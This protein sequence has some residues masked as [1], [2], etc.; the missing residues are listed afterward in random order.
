MD[1][2]RERLVVIA[3]VSVYT[4]VCLEESSFSSSSSSSS[5]SSEYTF[6]KINEESDYSSIQNNKHK[7]NLLY[8]NESC[9]FS[10]ITN[11][12]YKDFMNLFDSKFNAL[13]CCIEEE[14]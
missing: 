14:L 2:Q 5:S 6:E 10:L 1:Y 12:S 8:E 11:N 9:T 4:T 13:D 3:N 7:E